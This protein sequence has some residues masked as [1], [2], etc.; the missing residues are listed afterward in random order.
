M[1]KSTAGRY[2]NRFKEKSSINHTRFRLGLSTLKHQ[3]YTGGIVA[4]TTSQ[5]CNNEQD[6]TPL[7]YFLECPNHAAYRQDLL[8]GLRP[9]MDRLDIG[10]S[11]TQSVTNLIT[12]QHTALS[13]YDNVAW[14]YTVQEY[15]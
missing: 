4:T 15:I 2:Y 7:H 11:N 10:I 8:S 5:L 14:I 1:F 9:T 12:L 6:E 3:M 13:V